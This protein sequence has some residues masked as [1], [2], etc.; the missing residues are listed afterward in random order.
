MK[1]FICLIHWPILMIPVVPQQL[2]LVLL[3]SFP[4]SIHYP[5]FGIDVFNCFVLLLKVS[6][7]KVMGMDGS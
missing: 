4:L 7:E 1:I 3:Y 2:N 6:I 5:V